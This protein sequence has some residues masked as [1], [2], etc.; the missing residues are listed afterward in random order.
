M[1]APCPMFGLGRDIL[2]VRA[3]LPA[4]P[5]SDSQLTRRARAV[6]CIFLHA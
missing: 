1:E 2:G 5:Q 6:S 4:T 3:G